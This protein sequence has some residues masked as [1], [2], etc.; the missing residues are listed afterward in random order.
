MV[1]RCIYP[2]FHFFVSRSRSVARRVRVQAFVCVMCACNVVC[3]CALC[4][5]CDM[6]GV[7]MCR[8]VCRVVCRAWL[9]VCVESVWDGRFVFLCC[10]VLSCVV[11]CGVGLCVGLCVVCRGAFLLCLAQKTLPCVRSKRSRVYFQNA[12]V[13]KDTGVLNVHTRAFSTCTRERLSLL[14]SRLSPLVSPSLFFSCVSLSFSSLSL[15][16]TMITR[17]VGSLC[18]HSSDLP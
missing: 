2:S 3:V 9:C 5:V 18:T 12:R 10:G 1:R 15:T 4:V 14:F 7:C 11:V 13:T 17:P 6:C 8:V 16:M